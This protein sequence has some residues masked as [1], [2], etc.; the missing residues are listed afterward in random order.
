MN[1]VE[2]KLLG[3][4][5]KEHPARQ[6]FTP[7]PRLPRDNEARP[8]PFWGSNPIPMRPYVRPSMVVPPPML[9]EFDDDPRLNQVRPGRIGE[10]PVVPDYGSGLR[11]SLYR[12][13]A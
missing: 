10:V 7:R 3:R 12:G 13:M 2:I 6:M 5:L 1:D 11:R 4:Y 9:P 8:D